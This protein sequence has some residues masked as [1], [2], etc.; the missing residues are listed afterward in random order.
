[1]TDT[2]NK[3]SGMLHFKTTTGAT[4]RTFLVVLD[5]GAPGSGGRILWFDM[6]Y[7]KSGNHPKLSAP[8]TVAGQFVTDWVV[9]SFTGKPEPTGSMCLWGDQVEWVIQAEHLREV[10]EWV[11]A[12]YRAEGRE[13]PEES[14]PSLDLSRVG[15]A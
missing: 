3:G 14:F 12:C 13:V 4:E 15:R 6:H 9:A 11:I 2:T 10:R 1:M 7:G 5:A 8:L